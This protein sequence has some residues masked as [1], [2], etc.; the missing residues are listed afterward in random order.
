MEGALAPKSPPAGTKPPSHAPK[1]SLPLQ[2]RTPSPIP[3]GPLHV[4]RGTPSPRRSLALRIW[5]RAQE[6]AG[7]ASR[8]VS[9][10]L[11]GGVSC[12]AGWGGRH[13]SALKSPSLA[14]PLP[15]QLPR[16]EA[17]PEEQ[18]GARRRRRRQE[19]PGTAPPRA[20][21][22]AVSGKPSHGARSY[23]ICASWAQDPTR[24]AG[25]DS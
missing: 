14:P 25:G 23:A 19:A 20:P 17:G 13:L 16:D 9:P 24:A 1:C 21:R 2:R 5:I 22:G 10:A 15:E 11:G 4:L 6:E 12:R 18:G 7:W 3:L 8:P